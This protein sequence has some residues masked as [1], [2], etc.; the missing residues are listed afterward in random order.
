MDKARILR[1][2][3]VIGARGA[4]LDRLTQETALG[5]IAHVEVNGEP[6]LANK[7]YNGMPKGSRALAL[8]EWFKQFGKLAVNPDKKTSKAQPFVFDKEGTTDIEGGKNKP[9]FDCKK[10][11]SLAEEYDFEAKL[12]FF[13][14]QLK[15]QIE[16]GAVEPDDRISAIIKMEVK[17]KAAA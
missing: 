9:W 14:N 11:K 7:L 12:R 17:E 1:N 5:I 2:I 6:S 16:A 8:A 15:K 13:Q 3:A 4:N 10:A